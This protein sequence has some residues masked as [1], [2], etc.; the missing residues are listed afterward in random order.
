MPLWH[1]KSCQ[2]EWEGV[3]GPCDWCGGDGRLLAEKTHLE[4]FLETW[5]WGEDES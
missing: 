3:Q 1:C 4:L 2:H 5:R